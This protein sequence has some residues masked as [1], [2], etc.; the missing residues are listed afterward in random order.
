MIASDAPVFVD[1]RRAASAV[2]SGFT[3]VASV[4][5]SR[6]DVEA[7]AQRWQ[8]LENRSVDTTPFQSL[9]WVR[10]VYDF[11]AARGNEGFDPVLAMLEDG[12][13]LVA[14]LPLERVG[15]AARRALV[16]L[17]N[18]FGQYADLLLDPGM[19]AGVAVAQLLRAA[20]QAAPADVVSLLKVRDGSGLA[21]GL[22]RGRIETGTELAAP[23]V[24]LDA[25]PDFAAYFAT[26]RAK[27]RKN[28]RNARNRL[29]REGM[30]AHQVLV[31]P[32]AQRELIKRT[33]LGRAERL[34]EQG[35]T[36]RAFSDGSFPAFCESLAGRPDMD[37]LA[38]SLTHDDRPIAEQ[39]GFVQG[40]RYYAYVAARD[41]SNSDESP[42]KL[43]LAEVLRAC[44]EQGLAGCDL[45]VPAMPYKLTFA[46]GSVPVRDFAVP[47]TFRGWVLTR[48]WDVQLRPAIKA[49]LLRMPAGLRAPLMRLAGRS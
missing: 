3:P 47:V 48:L 5:Q 25:F 13:R 21:R 36:S 8:M 42:G 9:A 2:A 45:G 23:Y 44:A 30:V 16:P 14:I 4:V 37:L 49:A 28:M 12:R 39:W 1:R 46:T 22:P 7:L 35:L 33:L 27:T 17:G 19:D 31:E 20:I 43:H 38:F 15:T 26:I 24:A 18:G 32:A 6:Q 40:G 29:D 10:A 11:E 41:F 34:R